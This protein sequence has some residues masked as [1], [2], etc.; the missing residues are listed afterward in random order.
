[1]GFKALMN[2]VPVQQFECRFPDYFDK[3]LEITTNI[4]IKPEQLDNLVKQPLK[5]D[6]L[7]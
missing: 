6:S 5:N 4:D 7:L 3:M 2:K 1:M